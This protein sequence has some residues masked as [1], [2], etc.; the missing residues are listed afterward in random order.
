MLSKVRI[1]LGLVTDPVVNTSIHTCTI[2]HTHTVHD[3]CL[4]LTRRQMSNRAIIPFTGVDGWLSDVQGCP[5][6]ALDC[7]TSFDFY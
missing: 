1:G 7:E 3:Q 4:E 5:A 6:I 2:L